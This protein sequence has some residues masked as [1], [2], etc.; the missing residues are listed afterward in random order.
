M[1]RTQAVRVRNQH[2][3]LPTGAPVHTD[4]QPQGAAPLRRLRLRPGMDGRGGALRGRGRRVW[5]QAMASV[6]QVSGRLGCCAVGG[7]RA[8]GAAIAAAARCP[9]TTWGFIPA[10]GGVAMKAFLIIIVI[11]I[12]AWF[13]VY[14]GLALTP[15]PS[16]ERTDNVLI[17]IGP[18]MA[19]C[20]GAY[21]YSWIFTDLE[22]KTTRGRDVAWPG[23]WLNVYWDAPPPRIVLRLSGRAL[24][25][26]FGLG[27]ETRL[28]W[29]YE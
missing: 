18:V 24:H 9:M 22:G 15:T 11:V 21:F 5:R 6:C 26:V 4:R 10:A 13:M 28:T 2:L 29:S 19:E 8:S 7:G 20:Q 1:A 14:A 17:K 16:R 25:W 23:C 27:A 3:G 12:A